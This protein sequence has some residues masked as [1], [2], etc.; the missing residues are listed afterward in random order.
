[1]SDDAVKGGG[2]DNDV[3]SLL[4]L[5]TFKGPVN[6]DLLEAEWGA[7]YEGIYRANVVLEKVPPIEMDAALKARILGEARFIRAWQFYNL[8]TMFGG[9][10]LADHVLAPSEYNMSRAS[11]EEVWDLIE[12]DLQAAIPVLWKRSEYPAADLGRITRGTAQALLANMAAMYAVWHGADGLTN[13]AKRIAI[14]TQTVLLRY[15]LWPTT[16]TVLL[17]IA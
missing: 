6:T 14:L 7:D 1:M 15:G 3:N 12:S 16:Q 2:G 5:E 8:V 13:I 17:L 11:A 10:P 9:V 4:Q